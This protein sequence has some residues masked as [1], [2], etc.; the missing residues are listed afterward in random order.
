MAAGVAMQWAAGLCWRWSEGHFVALGIF[1][2]RR[3]AS[4][5]LI[6]FWR[7]EARIRVTSFGAYVRSPWRGRQSRE[8]P[9]PGAECGAPIP[10]RRA[11]GQRYLPLA[12]PPYLNDTRSHTGSRHLFGRAG[13]ARS[14][15]GWSSLRAPPD[16]EGAGGGRP[17]RRVVITRK[18]DVRCVGSGARPGARCPPGEAAS[19]ESSLARRGGQRPPAALYWSTTVWGMRPRDGSVTPSAAA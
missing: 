5:C 18:A 16:T 7:A 17:I 10:P 11:R 15:R 9:D 4:T 19:T 12:T 8:E 14:V 2:A 3:A 6:E 1:T 13:D